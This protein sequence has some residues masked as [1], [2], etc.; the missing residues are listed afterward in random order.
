MDN[1]KKEQNHHESL[2][3]PMLI[4]SY[5]D[6]EL[7]SEEFET[8][9]H[10]DIENTET[11][12][13]LEELRQVV[14]TESEL[15]LDDVDGF[16]LLEAI[17][18]D[19]DAYESEKAEHNSRIVSPVEKTSRQSGVRRWK[20]WIPAMVASALFLLSVPG[21]IQMF[22]S[23]PAPVTPDTPQTTVVYV[24]GNNHHNAQDVVCPVQPSYWHESQ[25]LGETDRIAAKAPQERSQSEQLTVDEMDNAIRLLIRRIENLEEANQQRLEKGDI[26]LQHN[27]PDE[28]VHQM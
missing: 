20:Q 7:K 6:G 24:D 16:A 14:K 26:S 4:E 5:F 9:H 11:W 13:A 22:G 18:N 17:H 10:E 2:M 1:Q 8:I 3:N 12:K 28:P 27:S 25:N 21:L 23:N 19:M 15:A